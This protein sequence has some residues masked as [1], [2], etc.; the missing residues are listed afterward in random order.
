MVKTVRIASIIATLSAIVFI[1]LPAVSGASVGKKKAEKSFEAQ[2]VVE[3]FKKT[4]GDRSRR[5]SD[6]VPPLVKEAQAFAL[7]LN[8]PKVVPTQQPVD[9]SRTALPPITPIQRGAKFNLIATCVHKSNPKLSVALIDEPGKDRRWVRQSVKVGHLIIKEVKDGFVVINDGTRTYEL[10]MAQKPVETSLVVG[11]SSADAK[12]LQTGRPAVLTEITKYQRTSLTP[13][14]LTT[15]KTPPK[16]V[17]KNKKTPPQI[18]AE[19]QELMNKFID[20]IDNIIAETGIDKAATEENL[21]KADALIE[22]YFSEL[23]NMRITGKEA[24]KLNDLGKKLD[25]QKNDPNQPVNN[26]IHQPGRDFYVPQK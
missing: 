4:Q 8:P 26:K 1:I 19:E 12:T 16:T 3:T 2:S 22:K 21:K 10:P 20:N 6:Q 24:K 11:K 25:S 9:R 5:K 13:E 14:K 18:T 17:Q 23:E 7:Y 15:A